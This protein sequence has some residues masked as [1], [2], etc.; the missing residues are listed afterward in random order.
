M[1]MPAGTPAVITDSIMTYIESK[2]I[3]VNDIYKKDCNTDE[4]LILSTSRMIGNGTHQASL[5]VTLLSSEKRQWT[6]ME[7]AGKFRKQVGKIEGIEKLQFGGG[8]H[9]GKPV[10]VAL[11]SNNFE[12]LHLA[13]EELKIELKKI[14]ELKD[15]IDDD[16]PGLREVNIELKDKAYALGLTTN[17]VVRQVR[18]GFF[19]G[20]VQRIL[21]GI[22]E[23]K[24]WIRFDESDRSSIIDLGNMRIRALNGYSI[25]LKEIADFDVS[26]GVMSINHIDGQRVVNVEADISN[27]GVSVPIVLSVIKTDI[28]PFIIEKYPEVFYSFEG[29]SYENQKTMDSMMKVVPA[30]LIMMFLIVSITFRSFI[31]AAIVFILIPFS[32]IGVFWGHFFQG[33]LFSILSFFGA[34]ALAGIVINDSLV[35]VSTFNRLLKNGYK[36]K[37]AIYEAGISRLRPVLLTSLTTIAGLAPLVIEKSHQA[38]FLSPMAISVSYGLFFGTILTLVMLPALLIIAN[39]TKG[40]LFRIFKGETLE[41]EMLEPAVREDFFVHE[42]SDDED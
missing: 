41:L 23:V 8:G 14:D 36:F 20:Q 3:E 6:S 26:R 42:Q 29:E 10:S 33:Y 38:Q 35:L 5:S 15:V 32:L 4:D 16:P 12:Q 21:R 18:S 30:I 31:Q 11:K 7:T 2:I 1:E 40:L 37:D 22:D 19:G 34:V 39:K 13:K 27:P 9:W 25:P 17:D 24:I 28:L